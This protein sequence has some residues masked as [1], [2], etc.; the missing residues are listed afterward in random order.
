MAHGKWM[1]ASRTRMAAERPKQGDVLCKSIQ[2]L[3]LRDEKLHGI[4]VPHS[5]TASYCQLFAL[6]DRV[7]VLPATTP[8]QPC[9]SIKSFPPER[10]KRSG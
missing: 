3:D 1:E 8:Q 9:P 10:E 2:N 5:S 6:F 7:R 4:V